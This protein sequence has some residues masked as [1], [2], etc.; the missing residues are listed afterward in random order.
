MHTEHLT[1]STEAAWWGPLGSHRQSPSCFLASHSSFTHPVSWVCVEIRWPSKAENESRWRPTGESYLNKKPCFSGASVPLGGGENFPPQLK[2]PSLHLRKR[3]WCF[4]TCFFHA[5]EQTDA[6]CDVSVIP[7]VAAGLR[8]WSR[9]CVP[10]HWVHDTRFVSL[11][12]R[13]FTDLVKWLMLHHQESKA[14]GAHERSDPA[15]GGRGVPASS[16]LIR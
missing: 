11:S 7:N 14:R 1:P 10:Q 12:S 2:T 9:P 15:Q 5:L 8:A 4:L 3:I 6:R 16:S 13:S